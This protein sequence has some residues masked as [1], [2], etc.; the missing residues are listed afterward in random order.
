MFVT[1]TVLNFKLITA[2]PVL[3]LCRSQA[4]NIERDISKL[5]SLN[6]HIYY[7]INLQQ[8]TRF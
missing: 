7:A 8:F 4:V 5:A 1:R 6:E 2:W 3:E